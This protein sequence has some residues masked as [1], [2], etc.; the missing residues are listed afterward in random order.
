MTTRTGGRILV[1]QLRI[2]GCDRIFTVP[3]ESFLAVLDALHDTPEINLVAC[4][5]EGGVTYM[6]DADGKMTGRPGVAFVTRVRHFSPGTSSPQ[7]NAIRSP[8]TASITA[9]GKAPGKS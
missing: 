3:G 1:D 5:Q 6:A 2:N 4:R 8:G 7:S 9:T